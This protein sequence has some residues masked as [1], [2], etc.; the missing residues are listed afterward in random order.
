LKKITAIFLILLF[1]FNLFGYRIYFYYA[2]HLSDI[3]LEQNLDKDNY[4]ESELISITIPFAMPYQHNSGDF[5]R[6]DG[7]ISLNGKTYKYVKRK[8]FDGNIIFLCLPDHNKMKL[9]A[10]K[11]TYVNNINDIQSD[12]SKKQDNSKSSI[13]KNLS[14]DYDQYF[15]GHEISLYSILTRHIFSNHVFSLPTILISSPG[16]PP[17]LA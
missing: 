7:E 2:Q 1:L 4:D 6:F 10:A 16:Q 9:E 3:I 12:N 5:E 14:T 13:G 11:N 17:E 8:Y 15:T